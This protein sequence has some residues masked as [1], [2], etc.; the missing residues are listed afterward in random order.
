MRERKEKK[1]LKGRISHILYEMYSAHTWA[2]Q[3]GHLRKWRH[4]LRHGQGFGFQP[5]QK[6]C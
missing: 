2:T 3:L 5:Q 1:K 4:E 6:I